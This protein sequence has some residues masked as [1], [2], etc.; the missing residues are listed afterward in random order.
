MIEMLKVTIAAKGANGQT[1]ERSISI[2]IPED[3][4]KK[5]HSCDLVPLVTEGLKS[6]ES[7][8]EKLLNWKG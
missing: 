5:Y 4:L 2:S 7:S 6:V 8:V 3:L 1:P